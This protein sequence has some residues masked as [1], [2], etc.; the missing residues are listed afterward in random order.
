MSHERPA[1]MGA[2]KKNNN[3][4]KPVSENK[5]KTA[6]EQR[7]SLPLGLR[8]YIFYSFNFLFL[9]HKQ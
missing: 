4:F 1:N 2:K 8:L 5:R 6:E 7:S 3:V 9:I